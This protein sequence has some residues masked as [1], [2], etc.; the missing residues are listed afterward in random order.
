MKGLRLRA[1]VLAAGKGTRLQP[2][3]SF[4]PKPA[5]PVAGVPI[6]G[7]TL[8]ALRRA[9]CEEAV[10]NLHHL[11]G[12]IR[13]RLGDAWEGMPLVYS[14]E[15]EI[16][17]TFGALGPVRERLREADVVVVINGDSLCAWPLRGL[18]RRHRRCGAAATLLVHRRA[19]APEL[20][21][22]VALDRD[23]RVVA[24]RDSTPIAP[25]ARRTVFA[26][27]HL[28][29]PRLLDRV[30]EDESDIVSDLY[31][32]LLAEGERIEA[33]I[34]RRRWHDLG[35][36]RR[37]LEGCLDRARGRRPEAL[38]RE[39]WISDA[40]EVPDRDTVLRSV[41]EAGARIGVGSDLDRVVVLP[42]A[43]VAPGSRLRETIV[44]PDVVFPGAVEVERRLVT[45]VP[46][47][48]RPGPDQSSLGELLY[49]RLEQARSARPE[50][51][52]PP[53][54]DSRSHPS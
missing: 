51:G 7:T 48:H 29:A 31:Q 8:S 44:G 46:V 32:P 12:A 35:T 33:V 40:A 10:V 20:G 14:E 49:T 28:L 26:G 4:L 36:P 16:L 38:W 13:D 15:P 18:V 11:G 54:G 43:V 47:G 19:P 42:G 1:L 41:I 37:Y 45:R 3:T 52:S 39:P 5:L 21:G 27:A 2:L 53:P 24:I 30:P 9:G 34:T 22:G 6:L 17:G 25:V 23:Q 50:T